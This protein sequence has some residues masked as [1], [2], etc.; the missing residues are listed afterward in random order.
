MPDIYTK[1]TEAAPQILAG[2]M[3]ALEIRAADPQLRAMLH[4]YLTDG[5]FP[6]GARV[7]EVGCGTG[8]ITRV[9]AS[10]PAVGETIG[11][12]PSPVFI[13]KARELAGGLS[14]LVFEEADGRSLPFAHNRF[15]AVVF[16][17]TLC[18][19]PEPESMLQEAVRVL[20]PGGCLAVFE[21]DYATATLATAARDPLNACAD[22]FREHFVHDPWLVRRL[23]ALLRVAG[24]EPQCVRSYGYVET[25]KP[26]FMLAGWVD[27]GADAL[28][29]SGRIGADMAAALKAEARRRIASGEYFGHIAYMSLVAPKPA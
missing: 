11:V 13:A 24:V 22:A 21:G 23:P 25:S 20:R 9:L 8:A 18:H 27:L 16:H 26:G 3:T 29:Y 4:T 1:V 2:L 12:D 6:E 14:A 7:L 15:D 17:T 10:W 19:V 28:A 5:A